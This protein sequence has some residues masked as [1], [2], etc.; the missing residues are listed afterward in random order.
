MRHS[1]GIWICRLSAGAPLFPRQK[2]AKLRMIRHELLKMLVCPENQ[3]SL[4]RASTELIAKLNHA[5][6]L[7]R[8]QNKAGQKLD[9]P[10]GDGLLREDERVL[11]PIVDDI[12]MMLVDEG[13]LLDQPG[14]EP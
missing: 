10:L 12:P 2:L 1:G 11:Y 8:L 9:K 14:L 6:A 5:I 4:N 7:G 3:S 13:I